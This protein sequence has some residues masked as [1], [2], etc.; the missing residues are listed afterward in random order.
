MVLL[1]FFKNSFLSTFFGLAN[2]KNTVGQ[3]T[4]DKVEVDSLGQELPRTVAVEF[5]G[6]E[7]GSYPVMWLELMRRF[8][9]SL[10][11]L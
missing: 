2:S 10:R 11:H 6:K 5:Y 3:L 1:Y 8:F 9:F 7:P 4:L